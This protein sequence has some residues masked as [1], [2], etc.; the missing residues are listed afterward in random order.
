MACY[1]EKHEEAPNL[2]FDV[3]WAKKKVEAGAGY[4]VTQMFFDNQKYFD[5]VDLCRKEGIT[6]P[7]VPGLKPICFLNQLNVLPKV[8]HV[9]FPEALSVELA[10]CKTDEQAC[11][12]GV[13]WCTM[14]ANEL[15]QKGVPS[16]HFYTF[17]ATESVRK[18]ATSVY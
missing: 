9:D 12:V 7:I 4:L 14:Q 1:P 3:Q 18:I 10:K 11:E 8:F 17:M 16:L 2:S 5:F 6:V 13:E 15:K